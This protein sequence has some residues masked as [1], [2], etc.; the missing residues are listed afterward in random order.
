MNVRHCLVILSHADV[1]EREEAVLPF[2]AGELLVNKG[3]GN[4]PCSVRTE[5]E[6]NNGIVRLDRCVFKADGGKNKFVREMLS[7]LVNRF[8]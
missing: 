4:F 8:I 2:K 6:E 3:T 7:V 5:V 1:I